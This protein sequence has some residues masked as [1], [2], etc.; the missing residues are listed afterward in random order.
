MDN[1][2]RHAPS[3]PYVVLAILFLAALAVFSAWQTTGQAIRNA[4]TAAA[5]DVHA[6]LGKPQAAVLSTIEGRFY[7]RGASIQAQSWPDFV[8]TLHDLD[9]EAC[10]DAQS[11]AGRLEGIVVIE[12]FTQHSPEDC[13]ETNDM[14]WRIMP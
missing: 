8:V 4:L 5:A 14:S 1:A 2:A 13:R 10:I 12:L 3:F 7:G 11:E 9:H 6:Q